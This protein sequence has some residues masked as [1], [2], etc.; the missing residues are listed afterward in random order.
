MS[1]NNV[2]CSNLMLTKQPSTY[3]LASHADYFRNRLY[4]PAQFKA[5][6][7]VTP[8]SNLGSKL[9]QAKSVSAPLRH[10][11]ITLQEK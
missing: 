11:G 5:Q 3:N 8:H 10:L 6:L 4:Q 9:L 7:E 1:S 2:P